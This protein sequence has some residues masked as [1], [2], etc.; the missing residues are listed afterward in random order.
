M[1]SRNRRY[2]IVPK[3]LTTV[4]L[5]CSST[6]MTYGQDIEQV[7]NE[8]LVKVSGG[9]SANSTL[10]HVSGI[11][12]RR[13]PLYWMLNANI[14]FNVL[15]VLNIPFSMSIS[16]QNKNFAQPQPFNRFGLSPRYKAVTLHLGHRTMNFSNYTLAGNLFLGAG[17][18]VQPKGA[19]WSVSAMYGQFAKP[20]EKSAQAGL[21]FAQPT[22]RRRGYGMKL[23]LGRDK[24]HVDLIIFKGKDDENSIEVT[25][26]VEVNPEE[27]LVMGFN[28]RHKIGSRISFQMEYAYSMYT[29]D[30]RLASVVVDGFTFAN[31]MGKLF[32]PNISSEYNSALQTKIQYHASGY[33]LHLNYRKI[34]PGYRTMGSSFLNN[35]LRDISGGVSWG[36]FQQKVN[37]ALNAGVQKNNLDN[38]LTSEVARVIFSGNINYTPSEKLNMNVTYSNFNS[39]T[40]QTQLRPDILQDT[41]QFFQLTR[42]GTVNFNYQTNKTVGLNHSLFLSSNIQDASDSESTSSIFFNLTGGHQMKIGDGWS[43]ST[44]YTYNSNK[45]LA[46]TQ[47]TTGPI[48]TFGRSFLNNKL[49]STWSASLLNAYLSGTRES[50]IS[51]IRWVNAWQIGKKHNVSVNVY[52]LNKSLDNKEQGQTINEIRGGINYSYRL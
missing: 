7:M 45:S 10:Y 6:L 50:T 17:V 5:I 28:T 27:N 9:F 20:V 24:H 41:L 34:D 2:R 13:D 21:V 11:E 26:E 32:T 48:F 43:V 36:M 35:D 1:K 46:I 29:R 4:L 23:G 51:N 16:Q 30:T 44:S 19:F 47:V 39:S 8:K 15:G 37:V 40:R 14:N 49:R 3:T 52:Y 12:N 42:S 22:F 33:Q 18:E 31:R 25:D 38:Q